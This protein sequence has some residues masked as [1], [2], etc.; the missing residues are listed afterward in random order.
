MNNDMS[1]PV[2]LSNANERHRFI[3]A[4]HT[5]LK[6][7]R[8]SFITHWREI[9]DYLLPRRG[10]YL[11]TDR[12]KGDKRNTKII[13]NTGTRAL[14]TL[15]AG[16][17]AGITSP[18]RPWFKLAPPD[19]QMA[20]F[21]PVRE[22]LHIVE[23]L[24]REVF[25]K[26]NLYNMLHSAYEELGGFGTTSMLIDEDYRDVIRC[27][28][29]TAGEY[30]IALDERLAVST[31]S[32]DYSLTTWQMVQKFGLD[33]VSPKVKD[34]Y[35]RGNYNQWFTVM[36]VVQSNL[37]REGGMPGPRGM[38]FAS[39]Y[40]EMDA[41]E[42]KLFLRESGYHEFPVVAPRWDVRGTDVYG[43]SPGMDALGDIKQ[44]QTQQKRKGQGIDKLVSPPMTA[45]PALRTQP[46]TTLPGG[47]TYVD[48]T[49]TNSGFKPAYQV[50]PQ[51]GELRLD[52]L[53]VQMRVKETFYE[54]LFRMMTDS[55][56]RQITA[57]EVQEKHEEKLLMLGPVLERLH[58]ELLDPIIDRSFAI[59]HRA[60]M[61]PDPPPELQDTNL[62]VEYISVL[63]QAQ[64]AVG[65]S[66]IERLV[67]FTTSMAQFQPEV[68]DK[69]DMDQ[70]VDEYSDMIGTPPGI[71][72]ADE[73]VEK[74]RQARA[75]L[76][77]QQAQAQQR[78]QAAQT[79]K[80]LSDTD[81]SGE[82][83]LSDILNPLA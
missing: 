66:G 34:A 49:Q 73:A 1:K 76:Q 47:V 58:N 69:L 5:A 19:P 63:A 32:R 22:W 44:L 83:A 75:D 70:A 61:F 21:A 6:Q 14:R 9:S 62:Q 18:A 42:S 30:A 7:E 71:V 12:N 80:T 4:Q 51:L 54:D 29:M 20:E 3:R 16:M 10:R 17:M 39:T 82:N 45:P 28:T 65:V 15:A 8:E 56:R 52:M 40:L 27:Y 53:D 36:Q 13:D 60:G 41:D 24:M 77:N 68:L 31:W 78:D 59:M 26:S 35:A 46:S 74:R 72:L 33:K 64:R 37:A 67:G 81:T 23:R 38:P 57:R 50:N 48:Q 2:D 79:A 25:N 11:M 43:R 55:D